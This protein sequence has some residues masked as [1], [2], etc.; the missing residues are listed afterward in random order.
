MIKWVCC[1]QMTNSLIR[2]F[3]A[4]YVTSE[5]VA[6]CSEKRFGSG[7]LASKHI[8]LKQCL[9]NVDAMS[10]HHVASTLI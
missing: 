1:M 10:C 3:T 5:C 6:S 9:I 7:I 2:L 4:Y 8:T